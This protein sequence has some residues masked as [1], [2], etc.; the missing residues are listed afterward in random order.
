MYTLHVYTKTS[1]KIIL[2]NVEEFTAGDL[3]FFVR[4]ANGTSLSVSRKDILYVDRKLRSGNYKRVLL[5]E[6]SVLRKKKMS[7]YNKNVDTKPTSR[8]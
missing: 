8:V 2:R 4:Y 7:R 6:Y 3:Y 5:K 1:G